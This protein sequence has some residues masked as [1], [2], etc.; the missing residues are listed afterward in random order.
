MFKHSL[1][2]DWELVMKKFFSDT[3]RIHGKRS[4]C[5]FAEVERN[6]FLPITSSEAVI[7]LWETR[8]S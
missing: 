2:F 1:T 4:E 7:G 3:A 5:C 8:K 6:T